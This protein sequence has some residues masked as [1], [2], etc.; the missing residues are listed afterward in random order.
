MIDPREQSGS[1]PDASSRAAARE[2]AG[3]HVG[4]TLRASRAGRI[5]PDIGGME[6]G[7]QG[8]TPSHDRASYSDPITA[9]SGED[10]PPEER[11]AGSA[12]TL[13]AFTDPHAADNLIDQGGFGTRATGRERSVAAPEHGS[14]TIVGRMG[15]NDLRD[16]GRDRRE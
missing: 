3:P 1:A 5:D 13:P 12:P 8:G 14:G 10:A 16:E 7:T 2:D 11:V 6:I 15:D 9:A 4:D